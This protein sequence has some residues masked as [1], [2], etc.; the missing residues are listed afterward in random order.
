MDGIEALDRRGRELLAELAADPAS[1]CWKQ[2][3]DLFYEVVWRYLRANHDTLPARVARYLRVD[4]VVAPSVLPGEVDEVAHEATKIALRRVREK[5]A[6]FDLERGS[7][8][9]WVIGNAQ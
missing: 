4:G 7:P 3:D 8:T 2:F 5:A 6:R 1:D 9:K